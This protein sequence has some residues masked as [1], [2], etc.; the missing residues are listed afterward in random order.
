LSLDLIQTGENRYRLEPHHDL[1]PEAIFEK[2]WAL[3]LLEH[4]IVQLRSEAAMAGKKDQFD[5]LKGFLTGGE[6]RVPYSQLAGSLGTTEDALKVA[7]HRLRKRFRDVLRE[8]IAQTVS[9][10]SE[11]QDEIRYLMSV[12]GR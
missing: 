9:D 3:T 2:Q 5:R 8:E 6:E 4:T 1:T 7:V 12:L 10:P 11:I